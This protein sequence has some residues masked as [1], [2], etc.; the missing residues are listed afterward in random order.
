MTT[1][2]IEISPVRIKA[3]MGYYTGALNTPK[4]GYLPLGFDTVA[5]ACAYLTNDYSCE[6]DGDGDFSVGGKYEMRHGQHSRPR[7]TIVS[8]KS[9][10]CT[11]AI[12]ADCEDIQSNSPH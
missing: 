3:N 10:R 6:Y 1:T 7:Y 8:A 4:D 5:H 2:P 9:G 11:K 12:K